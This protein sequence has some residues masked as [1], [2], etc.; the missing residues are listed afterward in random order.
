LLTVLGLFTVSNVKSYLN[1]FREK[2]VMLAEEFDRLVSTN[3][4]M[5]DGE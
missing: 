4:G 5:I 2:A 1:V 3:G